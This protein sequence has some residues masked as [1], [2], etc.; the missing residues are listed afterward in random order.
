MSAADRPSGSIDGF[1]VESVYAELLS[2]APENKMEPRLAPL[3]RA[4][5]VLGEPNKAFPIIHITGTNGKTSTARLIEGGLRAYGLRTGRYTSPHLTR[6]TERISID[7]EPVSDETFVRIWDEIRPYLDI[8]DGELEA[9]GEPRL[10]YFEALTILAFAVFADEPVDAAVI[11]VGLGGI[12]DATNVGDGTVSV[13]TPI[14]L[15]HTELLGDDVADIA[16][17]KAGIIKEGGFLISA[18]QPMEAA[19]VLLE[20]AR[21]TGVPFRFEGVEF[22]VES[23]VMAVGGQMVTVNGLAGRYEELLVPLHGAH[24]AQNAAVAVA[25][26]EAFIGGG[27][28]ELDV[29]LLRTG[30]STVTSPGRLEVVRT[31]PTIVVDA[32]HNPAGARASAEAL[33]ESFNFTTL[34]LVVGI[35]AEKDA[36]GI[37]SELREQLGDL[38]STVVLT[39][40]NSPRAIPAEELVQDAVDAGFADEDIRVE[41][42]LDN[43]LEL[44]VAKAEENNDLA[45]GVLVVGSIT[46]VAEARTLLGK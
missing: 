5:E 8:V 30:F 29:E 35:L 25:A 12:T 9:A 6:V 43:A 36:V 7:G 27:S 38:V 11:E 22:G 17:E 39:Q 40:S 32:A 10:T 13:I 20:K 21:E 18:A 31:A 2:R 16:Y 42:G 23:R 46:L 45:G 26:L 14:S 34:V 37:L 33:R 15:D 24:Q 4:M 28:K 3:F 44:A 41:A 1:S 19:T